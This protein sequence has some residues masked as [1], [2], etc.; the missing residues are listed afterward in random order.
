MKE[1]LGE[2]GGVL[3]RRAHTKK[4]KKIEMN[5]ENKKGEKKI[6]NETEKEERKR[7][8]KKNKMKKKREH[9]YHIYFF[10]KVAFLSEHEFL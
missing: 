1:K 5:R 7:M 3:R 8:S 4:G 2:F 9:A 6:I 10:F